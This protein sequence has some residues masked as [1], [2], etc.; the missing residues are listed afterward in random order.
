MSNTLQATYTLR[1]K[2]RLKDN[3]LFKARLNF[4]ETNKSSIFSFF[5]S[6]AMAPC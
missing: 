5:T 3:K 1:G 2:I 6:W 4:K